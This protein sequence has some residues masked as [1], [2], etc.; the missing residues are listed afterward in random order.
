VAAVTTLVLRGADGETL[1]RVGVLALIAG[2]AGT[3]LAIHAGSISGFVAATA[4]AGVGF[5]AGFQGGIRTLVPLAEP[6]ERVGLLS[7]VFAVSYLGLGVPAV[8]AG[9]LVSRGSALTTVATGYAVV[10][11]VLASA[12]LVGLLVTGRP[13]GHGSAVPSGANYSPEL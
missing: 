5:G 12:A 6:H 7:A 4:V 8:V 3:A 1:M 10:L 13:A 9:W 2:V 11:L